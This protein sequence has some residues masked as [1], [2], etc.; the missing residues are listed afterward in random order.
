V[1]EARASHPAAPPSL[2]SL[3]ALR[4]RRLP[5]TYATMPPWRWH[6]TCAGARDRVRPATAASRPG[7]SWG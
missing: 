7:R 4:A 1:H 3:R 6:A 2:V 5:P